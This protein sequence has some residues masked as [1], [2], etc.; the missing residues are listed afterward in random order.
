MSLLTTP[1]IKAIG[2]ACTTLLSALATTNSIGAVHSFP[3]FNPSPAVVSD[4]LNS[5]RN[6][7]LG[8]APPANYVGYQVLADWAGGD[9]PGTADQSSN[10][11]EIYLSSNA[12]GLGIA[13]SP[14]Q[15]A[16]IGYTNAPRFADNGALNTYAVTPLRFRGG[17]NTAYSGGANLFLNYGQLF[18]FGQNARLSNVRVSVATTIGEALSAQPITL[19]NGSNSFSQLYSRFNNVYWY[20]FTLANPVDA[21]NGEAMT[22]DTIGNTL[23]GGQFNAGADL[24]LYDSNGNVVSTNGGFFN[25]NHQPRD[26]LIIAG[27]PAASIYPNATGFGYAGN[28]LPAGTYYLAVGAANFSAGPDFHVSS[29]VDIAMPLI[30]QPLV[31]ISGSFKVNITFSQIA[32]PEPTTI[33][34]LAGA[35]L[36]L[37][38]RR[39]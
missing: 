2:L 13:S 20:E 30:G 34:V 5:W 14:P 16:G 25:P 11:A 29:V 21:T 15:S 9:F 19:V 37:C 17:F 31:E 1:T 7:N 35:C 33:T 36:A 3:A 27:L 39:R 24:A 38:F 4:A 12:A 22:I 23:I 6:Q 28:I 26:S 10:Y 18:K 32:V 8:A